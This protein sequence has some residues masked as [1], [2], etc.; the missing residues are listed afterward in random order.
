MFPLIATW[1]SNANLGRH[2]EFLVPSPTPV[3]IGQI[4][5]DVETSAI[6]SRLSILFAIGPLRIYHEDRLTLVLDTL[7]RLIFMAHPL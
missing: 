6:E 7:T 4:R 3:S 1:G 2:Q 5:K